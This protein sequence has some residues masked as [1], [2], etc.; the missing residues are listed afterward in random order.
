MQITI[1]RGA[2]EIGGNCID[3]STD[4]S[5]VIFDVG[6]PLVPFQEYRHDPWMLKKFSR[7][8]LLGFGY[9]PKVPGLFVGLSDHNRMG[10]NSAVRNLPPDAILL[11]H[12]HEDHTG[13]LQHTNESIPIYVTPGTNKMMLAGALFARQTSAPRDRTRVITPNVPVHLKDLL[14]TPFPVDH[15][16]YGGVAFL[17]EASGKRV[18]YSGDLRLHGRKPGMIRS[19]LEALRDRPIDLL[20]MEG[21]HFGQDEKTFPTEY[22]L[23]E[24]LVT[25]VAQSPSLVLASF[26]PQH[27]DR[28]VGFLRTAIRTNRIMVVDAY[29]A[30]VM[31]LIRNEL[32]L[33]QPGQDKN[34]RVFYPQFFEQGS[35]PKK[36]EKFYLA[37]LPARIGLDEIRETP[38]RYLMVFRPSMLASDFEN[39]LPPQTCCI[40]SRW[41]GYL[42]HPDWQTVQAKLTECDGTLVVLHTSG[43]IQAA[44]IRT[45]VSQLNPKTIVPI[46]TAYPHQFAE[47]IPNA[48]VATNGEP[49][50]VS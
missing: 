28:L 38:E 13:L 42:E 14:I 30:F 1:H 16:V 43:H 9:L 17:L 22:E 33:P 23:E 35:L 26:S 50:Q 32:S 11:S 39:Q 27:V 7:D 48:F 47:T 15:S 18:L 29:T 2:A 49:F 25:Q 46:H 36:L 24:Q 41:A 3:L 10:T 37:N 21:T 4:Q 20:L 12:A 40:Y 19:L 31:H 8:L 6:M 44:D 5:R 45:L 34:I